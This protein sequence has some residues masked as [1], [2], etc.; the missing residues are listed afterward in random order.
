MLSIFA[1]MCVEKLIDSGEMSRS[2]EIEDSIVRYYEQ[3]GD[4]LLIY[5]QNRSVQNP[6]I[7]PPAS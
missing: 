4:Y 3:A 5:L 2:A 7:K 6:T 1:A